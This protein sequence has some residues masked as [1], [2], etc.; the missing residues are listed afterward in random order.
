MILT[1]TY[2]ANLANGS[3]RKRIAFM[4]LELYQRLLLRG[5]NRG[6]T[7]QFP[8]VQQDVADLLGLTAIHV[9]RTLKKL[10]KERILL[11]ER[12]QLIILDYD[13]LYSMVG[14]LFEPLAAC[15]IAKV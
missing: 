4:A 5:L 12:H 6:Y 1:E 9:N 7:I 3:A 14:S 15:D 13:T 10:S 11:I 2:L 8:L